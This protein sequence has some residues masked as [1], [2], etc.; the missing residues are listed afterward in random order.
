[1][2]EIEIIK[3]QILE[4]LKEWDAIPNDDDSLDGLKDTE[5]IENDLQ[6]M[7]FNCC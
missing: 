2:D 6:V 7:I 1:M 3:T 4:L 5:S